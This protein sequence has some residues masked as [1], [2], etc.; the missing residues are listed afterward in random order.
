MNKVIYHVVTP[1]YWQ[2]FSERKAYT[3]PTFEEEGFI[4]CCTAEQIN[5]VL[6]TY[7]VDVPSILLL[8]IDRTLLESELKVEPANGQHFPHIYGAINKNAIIDIQEVNQ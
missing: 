4:H 6:T 8:K 5:Y 1:D 3:A 7:F 2:Q